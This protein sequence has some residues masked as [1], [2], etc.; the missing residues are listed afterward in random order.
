MFRLLKLRPPHGWNAVGWELA[1]VTLGVVIALGAQ[2]FVQSLHWKSEVRQTRQALDA[3]LSRDFAAFR[4]RLD[5][6]DCIIARA[7]ELLKWGK[8]LQTNKPIK[9]KHPLVAPPGFA[10]RT[11]V[12]DLI[13]GDIAS[14]IPL[15][16]R[17][18]YAGLYSGMRGFDSRTSEEGE[19]WTAIAEYEEATA[20]SGGDARK[21]LL[22]AN[23]LIGMSQRLPAWNTTMSRQ[24]REL[25]LVP[26]AN[27]LKTANPI[28][29]QIREAACEPYL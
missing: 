4:Y 27:L 2:E 29:P 11:E 24:A 28:I 1:I 18:N 20:L 14:R 25:G 9:L 21:L 26:D 23:G 12:W 10:I 22:A 5:Q 17:L 15:K 3:E 7:E 16:D 6:N 19:M 8:S 13:E